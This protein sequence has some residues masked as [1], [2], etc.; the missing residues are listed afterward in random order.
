MSQ[1]GTVLVPSAPILFVSVTERKNRFPEP[2]NFELDLLLT[3]LLRTA[4]Q[5]G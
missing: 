1:V 3:M 5:L 2:F 4:E